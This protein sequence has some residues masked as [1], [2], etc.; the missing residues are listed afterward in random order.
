MADLEYTVGV[1]TRDAT[2][3]LKNLQ[4]QVNQTSEVFSKLKGA[5]AGL[6]L[7]A[8]VKQSYE[9]ANSIRDLSAALGISIQNVLGFS[10]AMIAN[11]STIDRAR[12]GLTDFVKNLGEAARGSSELQKAFIETG[13][14]L[15]D[16]ANLS[17]AD[18]LRK[19]IR[20]LSQITDNARRSAVGMKIFG[21][22]TK[23]V[24]LA[25]VNR[26]IDEFI[27][28]SADSAT[29]VDAAGVANQNFKNSYIILQEEILR[30][31]LPLSEFVKELSSNR[32][33]I[34]ETITTI[35]DLAKVAAG[36]I[37]FAKI[38][39]WVAGAGVALTAFSANFKGLLSPVASAKNVFQTFK[40]E[41]IAAD[42]AKAAAS[43]TALGQAKRKLG[44]VT[45]SVVKGFGRLIPVLGQVWAAYELVSLGVEK[46]TGKDIGDW[47]DTWALQLET[48]V[49]DKFP[50]LH[51]QINELGDALGLAPS[52]L[53]QQ[54]T[55]EAVAEIKKILA[56]IEEAE[57]L[58]KARRIVIIAQ[59]EEL[60][61]QLQTYKDANATT[62]E[63]LKFE[64]SLLGLKTQQI[65]YQRKINDFTNKYKEQ[66]KGLTTQLDELNKKPEENAHL[67]EGIQEQLKKVKAEYES[68]LP[69]V[70][71][72]AK[73]IRD[74][75]VALEKAADEAEKLQEA[76][77]KVK[78]EAK[79]S[80]DFIRGLQESTADAA[81][82]LSTLN[83]NELQREVATIGRDIQTQVN[84][85]VRELQTLLASTA[86]PKLKADIQRQIKDIQAAG[87]TAIKTQTDIA[88]QSYEQQRSFQYGWK[89][90]FES[91]ADDATNAAKRAEDIFNKTTQTMEDSIVDFAKT[92]K[93]EFK[94]F[95]AS[96]V[97]DL[98]RSQVRQLLSNTFSIGGG[99]S[100]GGSTI[101]NTAKK[102]FSGFFA[103]GGFIPAGTFGV[104]GERGPELISGPAQVT[105]M[106]TSNVVYNINAVDALS[107]KQMV[108]Q[109]PAFIHA[110]AAQGGRGIPQTRR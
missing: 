41:L 78:D 62:I 75:S 2:K 4:T 76:M 30:A 9:M 87:S 81:F 103:D 35:L 82:E 66:V 102:L 37:I 45:G 15:N 96:V 84:D 53:T 93:F 8:V 22:S 57:E 72:I 26:D 80:T 105:P 47:L 38:G 10:Q 58:E 51:K 12:D 71:E 33:A 85:R 104:V 48:F 23:G 20:G 107:F 97:E 6:A 60:R 3:N 42:Y 17:E 101:I 108:A 92:G 7:G 70:E 43:T 44:I 28:K 89:K 54:S 16:L 52:P 64:E 46:L 40:K 49:R 24:D 50:E 13:V 91:Y 1:N 27:R 18:L 31:L 74:K 14:S 29:A 106:G 95:M 99:S 5:I 86:D 94:G 69:V 100:G 109:D 59:T 110:V 98:L 56:E 36:L 19:T 55:L 25:G 77:Q 39:K 21:E 63:A 65:D 34:R 79:T 68:Q 88:K 67:I 90:A 83:M 73:R 61:K 11:G 32:N